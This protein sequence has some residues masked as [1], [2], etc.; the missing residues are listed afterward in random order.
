MLKHI[1]FTSNLCNLLSITE[2]LIH[3]KGCKKTTLQDIIQRSGLSKG[4]IYHYVR[5][6]DELFGLILQIK[7][8]KINDE[9]LK[10]KENET[11]LEGPLH[12]ISNGMKYV[13][14]EAD[15]T[16]NIFIY[17]LGRKEEPA[18]ADILSHIYEHSIQLSVSWI[19][20][21]QRAGV[22]ADTLD[23][24]QTAMMFMTFSYGLRVRAMIDP[25]SMSDAS[26]E[27]HELMRN[28]LRKS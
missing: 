7:M 5:S 8:E 27:F 13:T 4:A 14:D 22:I 23:A 17:L 10:E 25:S 11:G 26:Q 12:A 20:A 16:N 6:K 1:R 28:T 24:N 21:G 19:E 2:Q 3:E 15:V 9:F 18:I